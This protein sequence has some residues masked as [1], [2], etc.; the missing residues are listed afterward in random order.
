MASTDQISDDRRVAVIAG[1][2][3]LIGSHC[4]DELLSSDR[5]KKV[6][7]IGR[8]KLSRDND[9][10]LSLVVDFDQLNT[11]DQLTGFDDVFCCLGTT[12]KQ[13]GSKEKFRKVDY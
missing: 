10:L 12:I 3:G 4:L 11:A 6:I 8:R 5:Y 1:A 7:A 2:T 9:K 13:A